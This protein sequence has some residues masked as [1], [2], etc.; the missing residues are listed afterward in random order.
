MAKALFGS[1]KLNFLTQFI[2]TSYAKRLKKKK[3]WPMLLSLSLI[4]LPVLILQRFK[5]RINELRNK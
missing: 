3:K 5:Q 1:L 2:L 4:L